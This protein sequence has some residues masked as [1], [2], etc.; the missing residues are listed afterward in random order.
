MEVFEYG[1]PAAMAIPHSIL[2]QLAGLCLEESGNKMYFSLGDI[3]FS[4][5]CGVH[6]E[7]LIRANLPLGFETLDLKVERS[8]R[9]R[10]QRRMAVISGRGIIGAAELYRESYYKLVPTESSTPTLE[11]NGIHMHRVSGVDPIVDARLKVTRVVRRGDSVLD[12]CTGL[13]YTA[14]QSLRLGAARVY[15]VEADENV[16]L[17]ASI[18][19]WSFRLRD[20]RV[21]QVLGDATRVVE[22]FEN[23][24]FD[25]IIHDPPRLMSETSSLYSIELYREFYRVLRRG[26]RVFHYTGEP[27]RL[28]GRNLPGR[29]SRLLRE[30]G[31]SE[32]RFSKRALGLYAVKI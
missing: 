11:I 28:R 31:F 12:V 8:F 25:V 26:G 1:K 32:V 27:G 30:A 29:V 7:I 6:G 19:P 9:G 14:I 13:G 21:V 16:L 10:S 3:R 4:A 15:T 23:S 18:N 5:E 22:F 24:K 20:P 2:D 17:L